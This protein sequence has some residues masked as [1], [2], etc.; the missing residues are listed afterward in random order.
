MSTYYEI[1]NVKISATQKEI[2]NAYVRQ[3]KKYH[4]DLF[5]NKD[6]ALSYTQLI[7]EAYA[8]LKDTVKRF[9]YDN[10][11]QFEG[12]TQKEYTANEKQ[13]YST[14]ENENEKIQHFQCDIC[15]KKDSSL[16]VTLFIYVYGILYFTWKKG[17]GKILCNKCRIKYA[18]LWNLHVWFLGWWSFYGFFY[19]FEA[20]FKNIKGGVL[21][22]Q[23]NA[24]L[25][26]I[27]AYDFYLNQNYEEAYKAISKSILFKTSKEA[28]E[29]RNYL[30]QFIPKQKKRSSF[31]DKI[32]SL[33]PLF[34]TVPSFVL[35]MV[36]TFFLLSLGPKNSNYSYNDYYYNQKNETPSLQ[37]YS[38]P[39]PGF[40][41]IP[42]PEKVIEFTEPELPLPRNGKVKYFVNKKPIAPLK[43]GTK[44]SDNYFI[45]LEDIYTHK[46]VMTIFI[47]GGQS[48]EVKV[49]L[50]S[51]YLKYATGEKWYGNKYHFGPY[52]NYY[53]ALETFDFSIEGD[54]VA[55]YSLE[56]YKQVGGNLTENIITVNDF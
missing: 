46:A 7:N 44:Y 51:Y 56:L 15:G 42:E 16:R 23:D 53:K 26:A 1:L 30:A 18:I 28:E 55:G 25:L 49:P 29:F 41:S 40:T 17:W 36:F 50:G 54:Q 34:F 9:E 3:I 33:N 5:P 43:I 11:L 27:L 47:H 37:N 45:K 38:N 10:K 4:P 14:N 13:D 22:E 12:K 8:V 6:E 39:N 31:K 20:L 48:A 21:P 35:T 52:T 32:L 19:S 24:S 2:R